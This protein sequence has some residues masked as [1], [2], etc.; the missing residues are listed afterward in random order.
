M[1]LTDRREQLHAETDTENGATGITCKISDLGTKSG[2]MEL[3][4]GCRK[5]S[6][7]GKNKSINGTHDSRSVDNHHFLCDLRQRALDRP[8]IRH[9]YVNDTHRCGDPGTKGVHGLSVVVVDL[10]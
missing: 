7:A 2:A 4:H 9:S 6:D 1:F 5:G 8:E 3:I 10:G